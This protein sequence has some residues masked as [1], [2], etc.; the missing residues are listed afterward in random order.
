MTHRSTHADAVAARAS[1]ALA[2]EHN[3]FLLVV[4]LRLLPT[5]LIP[6]LGPLCIRSFAQAR[7]YKGEIMDF[8]TKVYE[9]DIHAY[10]DIV[11][12]HLVDW[13]HANPQARLI[14]I[15]ILFSGVFPRALE[16]ADIVKEIN[17][18]VIVVMGGI[19]PTIHHK[20]ILANCPQIDQIVVGEGESPWVHMLADVYGTR[21]HPIGMVGEK[22][23]SA[24]DS[25]PLARRTIFAPVTTRQNIHE[26]GVTDYSGIDFPGYHSPDIANW[27]NPKGQEIICAAPIIT[28][29]SCPF[30]CNFCSI[31]AVH[32]APTTFRYRPARD[33]LEELKQLHFEHGINY[34]FVVDDCANC[35]KKSAIELYSA[36]ANSDLDISLEFQ[37]GLRISTLDDEVIDAMAAAG[38]I[39]AGLAIESGN[40]HIRN[41]IVGKALK[42]EKIYEVYEYFQKAHPHIWL[43]AFFIIGLPEETH[44]SLDDTEN[45]ARDLEWVYPV[46]NTAVP[47]VG[48]RLWD[49]CVTDDLLLIQ[50]HEAWR[51]CIMHGWGLNEE[52]WTMK[53][54]G[55][56]LSPES[57]VLE[58]YAMTIEE[59]RVR[60]DRLVA[61]QAERLPKVKG[62]LLVAVLG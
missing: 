50:Q 34:F 27:Y 45:L 53:N 54:A 16:I 46:F 49:Q 58:P 4:P 2:A 42:K 48:T 20:E 55:V 47:H 13:I 14:G 38:M 8:N 10:H 23:R 36:I 21:D 6:P 62:R 1:S 33:V 19:H 12:A 57:F 7:G 3:D 30:K 22:E 18:D 32:G 28:S 51:E 56:V 29:R 26:L 61:L 15:N 40:D 9:Q 17:P 41:E 60:R 52:P 44:R 39:R 37:S 31:H 43:L 11:R 25:N 5:P 35:G 59:L 24:T